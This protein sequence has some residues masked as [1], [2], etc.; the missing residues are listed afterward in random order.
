MSV[1]GTDVGGEVA[2]PETK[3]AA[4][5]GTAPTALSG[6]VVLYALISPICQFENASILPGFFK[7]VDALWMM[8]FVRLFFLG[9]QENGP[10]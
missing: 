10:P 2:T 4:P 9:K 8:T 3:R 6:I 1:P 7:H 5:E